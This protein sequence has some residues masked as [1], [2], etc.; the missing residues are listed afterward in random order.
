MIPFQVDPSWYEHYWWREQAPRRRW[1]KAALIG[2]AACIDR[3]LW[4]SLKY[5]GSVLILI[6]AGDF[7]SADPDLGNRATQRG[8]QIGAV[9]EVAFFSVQHALERSPFEPQHVD[10]AM[11]RVDAGGVA[12]DV[13]EPLDGVEAAE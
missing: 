1:L 7:R 12:D 13:D 6:L 2:A 4:A 9:N 5:L 11:L 3:L 10:V 8:D